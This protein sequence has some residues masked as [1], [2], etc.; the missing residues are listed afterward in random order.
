VTS[1]SPEKCVPAAPPSSSGTGIT[2]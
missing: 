1:P 2:L